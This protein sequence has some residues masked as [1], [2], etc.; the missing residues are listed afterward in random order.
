MKLVC[1]CSHIKI[2]RAS[3]ASNRRLRLVFDFWPSCQRSCDRSTFFSY[4]KTNFFFSAPITKLTRF[5]CS[6]QQW[7][8]EGVRLASDLMWGALLISYYQWILFVLFKWFSHNLFGRSQSFLF[9]SRGVEFG[10]LWAPAHRTEQLFLNNKHTQHRCQSARGWAGWEKKLWPQPYPCYGHSH[11]A[12]KD[13]K[14]LFF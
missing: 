4:M 5:F 2:P 7:T 10:S 14:I 3:R 9:L 1:I 6:P 13:T 8:R 12:S 11:L